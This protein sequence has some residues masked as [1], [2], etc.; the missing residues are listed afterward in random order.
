MSTVFLGYNQIGY[1]SSLLLRCFLFRTEEESAKREW[2]AID[3]WR[4][5]GDQGKVKNERRSPFS[6]SRLPLH[7]S[8]ERE[9]S[10]YGAAISQFQK[11]SLLKWGQV[12]N[13]SCENQFYLNEKNQLISDLRLCTYPLHHHTNV[14]KLP[15]LC[16]G[17]SSLVFNKTLSI[18]ATL[19]ILRR[20]RLLY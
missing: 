8:R 19:L 2:H 15:R 12:Q 6:P 18:L 1:F 13:L 17:I 4:S 11:P 3:W 9:T 5:T 16:K 10:G 20:S 14:S 7:A